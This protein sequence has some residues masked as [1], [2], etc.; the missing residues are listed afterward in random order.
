MRRE[1]L[2]GAASCT[3]ARDASRRG[4]GEE[5][6]RRGDLI[7]ASFP[8]I[9][10]LHGKY[11]FRCRRVR[12]VFPPENADLLTTNDRQ[13]GEKL[14]CFEGFSAPSA[15]PSAPHPRAD[16]APWGTPAIGQTGGK[17]QGTFAG[18]SRGAATGRDRDVACGEALAQRAARRA[19][20]DNTGENRR[21]CFPARRWGSSSAGR[22]PRSQRG[23][24]GFNPL[25]L[26]HLSFPHNKH[27]PGD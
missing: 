5:S 3:N 16:C 22:A 13:N 24:R 2:P 19:R 7:F 18:C 21:E 10:F 6:I 9:C 1:P 20:I 26:H 4:R 14:Y 23:G 12:S 25:L 15:Q 11:F 27:A 8:P 17:T